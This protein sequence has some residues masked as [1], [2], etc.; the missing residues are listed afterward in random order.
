MMANQP[1]QLQP[2]AVVGQSLM[3]LRYCRYPCRLATVRTPRCID[4]NLA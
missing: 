3:D 4:W 2:L 1:A